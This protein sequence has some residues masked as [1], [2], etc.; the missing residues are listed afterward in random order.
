MADQSALRLDKWLWYARFFKTRSLATK[1]IS[2]GKLRLD[3]QVMAKPHRGA[4]IG[5]VLTF[6]QGRDV[7]V[8]KI[9]DL[10]TRRG[11]AEEARTLYEDMAPI[12]K[13]PDDAK[14][15]AEQFESRD[16]GSGRPTKR[17]RRETE[18]LKDPFA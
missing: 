16:T 4:K 1:L 8:I 13:K 5:M 3:G 14:K 9:L 6:A 2:G 18:R 12:E 11:P 15:T 7:R 10:G 17:Q